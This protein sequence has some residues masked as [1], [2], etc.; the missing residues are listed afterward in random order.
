[1]LGCGLPNCAWFLKGLSAV[2]AY[3]VFI[4]NTVCIL[5]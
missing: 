2:A 1:M 5:T 3:S 4:L